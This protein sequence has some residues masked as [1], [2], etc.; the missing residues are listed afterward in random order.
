MDVVQ[1][2]L[3][4]EYGTYFNIGSDIRYVVVPDNIDNISV[5]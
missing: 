1:E 2:R 3:E 5:H 4:R